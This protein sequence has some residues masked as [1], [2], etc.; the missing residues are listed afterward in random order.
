VESR[1]RGIGRDSQDAR[2]VQL[3]RDLRALEV[4]C[5]HLARRL[6][7]VRQS[8]SNAPITCHDSMCKLLYAQANAA[9]IMLR[10]AT[11]ALLENLGEEEDLLA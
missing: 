4:S 2:Q 11:I 7:S 10:A 6:E 5:A 9:R 8:L 1:N 3:V